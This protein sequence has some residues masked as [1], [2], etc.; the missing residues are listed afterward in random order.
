[1]TTLATITARRKW[2]NSDARHYQGLV[3]SE[4]RLSHLPGQQIPSNLCARFEVLRRLERPARQRTLSQSRAA[5]LKL[6]LLD[7]VGGAHERVPKLSAYH[8]RNS[9]RIC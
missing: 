1:M 6:A 5:H 2:L 8:F 3:T 4:L 9:D 7:L